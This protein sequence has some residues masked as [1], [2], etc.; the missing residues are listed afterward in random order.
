MSDL[1]LKR[2]LPTPDATGRIQFATR[3]ALDQ[4]K[5]GTYEL[6]VI[7]ESAN[8]SAASVARFRVDP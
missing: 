2:T 3:I 7:V 8:G 6:R 4:L 1:Q 5:P